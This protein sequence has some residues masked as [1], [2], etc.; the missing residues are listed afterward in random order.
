MRMKRGSALKQ[1]ETVKEMG[2]SSHGDGEPRGTSTRPGPGISLKL[3]V[4][5]ACVAPLLSPCFAARADGKMLGEAGGTYGRG[6]AFIGGFSPPRRFLVMQTGGAGRDAAE[7]AAWLRLRGSTGAPLASSIKVRSSSPSPASRLSA[8]KWS[9]DEEKGVKMMDARGPKGSFPESQAARGAG[10]PFDAEGAELPQYGGD[11]R[12]GGGGGGGM[13]EDDEDDG[14]LGVQGEGHE[15]AS[16]FMGGNEW[17]PWTEVGV[18]R[19]V[20]MPEGSFPTSQEGEQKVERKERDIEDEEDSKGTPD[21]YLSETLLKSEK[22]MMGYSIGGAPRVRRGKRG[23]RSVTF[24]D[25]DGPYQDVASR[26]G[27]S[28]TGWLNKQRAEVG[29]GSRGEADEEAAWG[30]KAFYK[31]EPEAIARY[32]YGRPL[33]VMLRLID[34]GVPLGIWAGSVLL[35]KFTGKLQENEK[36]RA[37]ELRGVCTLLSA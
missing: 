3:A 25:G 8:T 18:K 6:A 28:V 34:A 30:S 7:R 4:L 23:M 11:E 33:A 10:S 26:D 13:R 29:W 1:A 22:F 27:M 16:D 20:S 31:Y 15:A 36:L 19:F 24:S 5:S 12:V 2:S 9:A 21:V 14:R 37:K 17:T 32:Y 35:D